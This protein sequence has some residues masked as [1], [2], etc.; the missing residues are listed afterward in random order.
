MPQYDTILVALTGLFGALVGG[1]A[2]VLAAFLTARAQ[3]NQEAMRWQRD[4]ADRFLRERRQVYARYLAALSD[5]SAAVAYYQAYHLIARKISDSGNTLPEQRAFAMEKLG[6][7]SDLLSQIRE[8]IALIASRSVVKASAKTALK[9]LRIT[10]AADCRG[11]GPLSSEE[12][13]SMA[14]ELNDSGNSFL[15]AARG[16]LGFEKW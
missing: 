12:L 6:A 4:R 14:A 13:A 15:M 9:L 7:A 2:A 8:E 5:A 10:V 1:A 3:S 16:E 11:E